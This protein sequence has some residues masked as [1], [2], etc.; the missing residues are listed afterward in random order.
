MSHFQPVFV[1]PSENHYE[2]VGIDPVDADENHYE[3]VTVDPND[4]TDTTQK[5]GQELA[6]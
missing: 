1:H 5:P 4:T 3:P 6:F 2:P